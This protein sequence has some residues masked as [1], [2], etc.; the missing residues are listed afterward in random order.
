MNIKAAIG[1]F[2]WKNSSIEWSPEIKFDSFTKV[3]QRARKI[4]RTQHILTAPRGIIIGCDMAGRGAVAFC[5]A[6]VA[7]G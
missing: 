1:A 5:G 6:K 7:L 4:K 2:R 3:M